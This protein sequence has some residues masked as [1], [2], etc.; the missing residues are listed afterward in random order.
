M[1]WDSIGIEAIK[2]AKSKG[3]HQSLNFTV[4]RL[5]V[6]SELFEIL[7]AHRK[8]KFADYQTF[9]MKKAK[10]QTYN[11]MP[12]FEEHIKDTVED[13]IAD[14]MLRA[15]GFCQLYNIRLN[16]HFPY[17]SGLCENVKDGLTNLSYICQERI[18]LPETLSYCLEAVSK[19]KSRIDGGVLEAIS[20]LAIII[21]YYTIDIEYFISIKN[22]YNRERIFK[23]RY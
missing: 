3:Y 5:M 4:D 23:S 21:E 14:F 22:E 6:I 9:E 16:K 1:N 17:L 13:E 11:Q 19:N 18:D 8:N 7:E 15:S 20:Y 10:Y 2:I 12:W